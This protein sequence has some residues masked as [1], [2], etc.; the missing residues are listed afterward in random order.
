MQNKISLAMITFN[1]GHRIHRALESVIGLVDQVVVIDSFSKDNTLE[2]VQGFQDRLNIKIIEREFEGYIEQ[3]NFAIQQCEYDLILSLDGDEAVDEK[4]KNEILQLKS[5]ENQYAGFY[6]KRMTNY[7]GFWV[8]H[9]GWYPDWKLRLFDRRFARWAGEN[10][11]DIIQIDNQKSTD[12]RNGNILHYSYASITDHVNQTN[13]FTTIAA[14]AA[15]QN[16]K[17]SSFLG[18]LIRG[19]LK[20][21][22]DYFIK[23]GILDGRYGIIIC[24]INS[25]YVFLKYSKIY[26]LQNGKSID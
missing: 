22:R 8:K 3:K 20:F 14:K 19:I 26:E 18:P 7:N 17:R 23:L 15:Y 5:N 25:L 9:C 2:V 13:R 16:G 6:F 10:P 12:K 24:T 4:M 11:H 1:E 21:F